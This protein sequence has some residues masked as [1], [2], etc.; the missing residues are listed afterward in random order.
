M[1]KHGPCR[2]LAVHARL[3]LKHIPGHASQDLAQ[4]IHILNPGCSS[5]GAAPCAPEARQNLTRRWSTGRVQAL[6]LHRLVCLRS[7]CA[8][9]SN[10]LG[11]VT[12][13]CTGMSWGAPTSAKQLVS[14]PCIGSPWGD[15]S[16]AEQ[17]MSLAWS[18]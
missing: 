18:A 7:S 10:P 15:P 12:L 1:L 5:W 3:W 8:G 4:A 13:A 9:T 11:L 16:R 6:E 17:L 2:P 14:L